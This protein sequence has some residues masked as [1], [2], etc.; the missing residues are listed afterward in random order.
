MRTRLTKI[1]LNRCP[2]PYFAQVSI[3]SRSCTSPGSL[4]LEDTQVTPRLPVTN[5]SGLPREASNNVLAQFCLDHVN[6]HRFFRLWQRCTPNMFL[7]RLFQWN[8]S[9]GQMKMSAAVVNPPREMGPSWRIRTNLYQWTIDECT[10]SRCVFDVTLFSVIQ[11]LHQLQSFN[12]IDISPIYLY[13]YIA[14]SLLV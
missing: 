7:D 10:C 1:Q 6:H 2:G 11:L 9:L 4:Y 13:I 14:F 3:G 5:I 8:R 12:W